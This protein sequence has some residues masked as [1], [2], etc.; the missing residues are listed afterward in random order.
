MMLELPAILA[1]SVSHAG[2]RAH[3]TPATVDRATLQRL[4]AADATAKV[5]IVMP[6]A[7]AVPFQLAE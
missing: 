2:S 6:L 1:L 3:G 4:Y 5:R 7:D